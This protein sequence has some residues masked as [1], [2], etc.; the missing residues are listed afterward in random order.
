M[1]VGR[2]EQLL[3]CYGKEDERDSTARPRHKEA[4]TSSPSTTFERGLFWSKLR[5]E[6][7]HGIVQLAEVNESKSSLAR[8]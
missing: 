8:S 7:E 1:L 2:I 6:T 5:G 4:W 3:I